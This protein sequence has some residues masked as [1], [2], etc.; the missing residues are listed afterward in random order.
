MPAATGGAAMTIPLQRGIVYGPLLSRRLGRSLGINILPE[1]LKVCNFNCAYCQYGWTPALPT[2][3]SWPDARAIENA[4]RASLTASAA[5]DRLTL[6]GNGE[7]TLHP[8]FA[9]VVERLID[10]RAGFAPRARLAILSNAST[11]DDRRV[12]RAL[13]RLDE[14]YMKLDAGD[15]QTFRRMN[16][17]R[18]PIER[19]IAG[20]ANLPDVVLQS[21]FVSDGGR[22][23][24]VKPEAVDRWFDAVV[25]IAPREVHVYSLDRPPAHGRLGQVPRG[26]LETI[27]ARV[28]GAGIAASVY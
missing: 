13:G 8:A 7:P 23:D 28:R 15:A 20:I 24:N 26:M 25:R 19:I 4:V 3:S 16:G 6:A 17:G 18:M 21:M 11:L 2:G 22:I 5:V 14:R 10:T 9:D 27:A 1:G 12:S